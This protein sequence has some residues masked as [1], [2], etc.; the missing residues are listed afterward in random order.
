MNVSDAIK[1]AYRS[2]TVHKNLIIRIPSLNMT[3]RNEKI[4]SESMSLKENLISG[5]NFEF[6]GCVA[7]QFS[8]IVNGISDN[9]QGKFIE[10]SIKTDETEEIPLFMDMLK[11]WKDRQIEHSKRLL[12][13]MRCAKKEEKAF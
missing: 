7:S 9:I 2:D 10:V 5:N 11:V 1:E 6:V 8:V 3:I 4:W 12:P 13:M